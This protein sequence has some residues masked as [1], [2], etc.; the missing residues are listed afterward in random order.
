M[1]R[2][3]RTPIVSGSRSRGWRAG[4][5]LAAIVL[6]GCAAISVV[7]EWRNAAAQGRRRAALALVRADRFADAAPL[8]QEALRRNPRDR[9]VLQALALGHVTSNQP[10]E[11]E[12]A[13]TRW[14]EAEPRNPKPLLLRMDLWNRLGR[15]EAALADGLRLLELQPENDTI[16][17]GVVALLMAAGRLDEAERQARVGV[18]K[19]ASDVEGRLQLARIHHLRGQRQAAAVVVDTILTRQ[20]DYAPAVLLKGILTR[21]AGRP[22]QAIE[23]LQQALA[24]I[25]PGKD[26]QAARYHLA[27]AL[28]DCGRADEAQPIL[29]QFRRHEEA[30]RLRSD[31]DLL[32]DQQDLQFRAA[33]ALLE[34]GRPESAV[35]LLRRLIDRRPDCKPAH[36]MLAD[37]YHRQGQTDLAERHHRLATTPP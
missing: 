21:E 27:L 18:E 34:T 26:Q 19:R 9:E 28:T 37:H 12:A 31:A 23:P 14:G 15:R 6:L 4:A 30:D 16:E 11:A 13:L 8:L 29:T 2:P 24:R 25:P 32:P 36:R 22:H 5:L 17:R 20:P 7:R 35:D 33:A 10:A 3:T 1:T